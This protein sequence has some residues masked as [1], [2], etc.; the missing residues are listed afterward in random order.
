[1][2]GDTKNI[3]EKILWHPSPTMLNT[4]D[5]QV[6]LSH[7]LLGLGEGTPFSLPASPLRGSG[8]AAGPQW[9]AAGTGS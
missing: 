2:S 7:P 4:V 9:G 8:K 1:M 5:L 6:W 3:L